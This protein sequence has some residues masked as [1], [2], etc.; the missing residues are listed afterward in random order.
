ME[1]KVLVQT[2]IDF[3]PEDKLKAAFYLGRLLK[4]KCSEYIEFIL[5]DIVQKIDNTAHYSYELSQS[6]TISGNPIVINFDETDFII[7]SEWE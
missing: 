4:P 1:D 6:D 7:K 3:R 5:N 2:I